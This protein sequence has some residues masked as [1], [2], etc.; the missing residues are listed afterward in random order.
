MKN[1]DDFQNGTAIGRKSVIGFGIAAAGL[2]TAITLLSDAPPGAPAVTVAEVVADVE[3][4]VVTWRGENLSRSSCEASY[5]SGTTHGASDTI[6]RG[7]FEVATPLDEGAAVGHAWLRIRCGED[8]RVLAR[9]VSTASPCLEGDCPNRTP[10]MRFTIDPTQFPAQVKPA[11][12]ARFTRAVA[13]KGYRVVGSIRSRLSLSEAGRAVSFRYDILE[14]NVSDIVECEMSGWIKGTIGQAGD[15]ESLSVHNVTARL[16][17]E[18]TWK[19]GCWLR[20]MFEEEDIGSEARQSVA[21]ALRSLPEQT[22]VHGV[23]AAVNQLTSDRTIGDRIA[24][25]MVRGGLVSSV[26]MPRPGAVDLIIWQ[27]HEERGATRHG[28]NMAA[29]PTVWPANGSAG[30]VTVSYSLVNQLLEMLLAERPFR[31]IAG[32]RQGPEASFLNAAGQVIGEWMAE[33]NRSEW[34][35]IANVSFLDDL[36]FRV[37]LAIFPEGDDRMRVFVKGIELFE[38][39]SEETDVPMRYELWA[40]GR[41]SLACPDPGLSS[42]DHGDKEYLRQRLTMHPTIESRERRDPLHR[43]AT[44]LGMTAGAWLREES[45]SLIPTSEFRPLE[46]LTRAFSGL[47]LDLSRPL[48]FAGR[49]PLILNVDHIGNVAGGAIQVRFSHD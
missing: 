2:L 26:S 35:K 36:D 17:T 48:R 28:P 12:D 25:R 30:T 46:E 31:E 7:P 38:D 21:A 1:Q 16:D 22:F 18:G 20:D 3:R 44:R 29:M 34:P 15:G 24:A 14:A 10:M 8:T 13:D 37:P 23:A 40:E 32:N 39:A 11:F 5:P 49:S 19:P 6:P 45:N 9:E 4:N 43:S 47:C 41:S 27:E 42:T 33:A